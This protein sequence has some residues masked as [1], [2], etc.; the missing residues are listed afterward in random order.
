MRTAT[1]AGST[2]RWARIGDP[3]DLATDIGP[4]IDDE[5]RERIETYCHAAE[6][7]GLLLKRL[8]ASGKGRFVPPTVLRVEGIENL[9]EEVF[10][11]VLHVATYDVCAIDA[12][13]DAINAAGYGL[14]FGLHTRIDDRVPH[15]VDRVRAGNI[16]VNRNQIGAAVGSQPF[17]GEAASGTGP[18]AGGPHY[19]RRL[20]D[21]AAATG[22]APSGA[23]LDEASLAAGIAESARGL[24]TRPHRRG[25]TGHSRTA[26][27]G[28]SGST[29]R[30]PHGD[31]VNAGSI[32]GVDDARIRRFRFAPLDLPGPTG[33]SN[34][35]SF[36]PRGVVLCLGPGAATAKAQAATALD[37]GNAVVVVAHGATAALESLV[38]KP[39][40]AI[41]DGQL[42]PETLAAVGGIAAVACSA[43]RGVLAAI[44]KALARRPGPIPPLITEPDAAERY[45][46][47]RHVCTDTTAA[48]GNAS[49]LA[50]ADA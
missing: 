4:V 27:T 1:G 14:T 23:V 34:R 6:R 30:V 7:D 44:R 40:I 21:G 32:P 38:A 16:Y 25:E 46:L 9:A 8:T 13:V 33:E 36:A 2:P 29:G 39:R 35:L 45:V 15:V 28:G 17:G 18:K 24:A 50:Q 19:V 10:G 20:M 43:D 12:V 48:G 37:A 47:E 22:G 3:W 41:L 31:D 49:L 11:P 26:F 5:A 42:D